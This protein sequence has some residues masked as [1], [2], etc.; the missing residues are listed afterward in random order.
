MIVSFS[1]LFPLSDVDSWL[2]NF[3]LDVFLLGV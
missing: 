3:L 2:F 1:Y